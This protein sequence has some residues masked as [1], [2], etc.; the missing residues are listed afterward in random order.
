MR[1][2]AKSI[3]AIVTSRAAPAEFVL[4]S[5]SNGLPPPLLPLEL[6]CEAAF[7]GVAVGDEEVS[8]A[9]V[10][11]GADVV[12][13]RLVAVSVLLVAVVVKTSLLVLDACRVDVVPTPED[14]V[15]GFA[16]VAGLVGVLSLPKTAFALVQSPRGPALFR[17]AAI[18]FVP[19]MSSSPQA[20]FTSAARAWSA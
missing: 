10:E 1:E 20:L 16:D 4:P 11:D 9:I 6:E 13:V 8:S 3:A 18:T 12:L 7:V 17:N 2:T 5:V 14:D 19:R 15:D